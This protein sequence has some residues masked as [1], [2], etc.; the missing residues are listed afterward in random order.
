MDVLLDA[1]TRAPGTSVDEGQCSAGLRSVVSNTEGFG[2][3]SGEQ[4]A[5]EAGTQLSR[6][7]VRRLSGTAP[8]LYECRI[9][10]RTYERA[11]RLSRHM[12]THENARRHPCQRCPKSFNRADL[13]SRHQ[14]THTRSDLTSSP[15]H[16]SIQRTNRAGQACVGCAAAKARCEDQKPCRR[17]QTKGMVCEVPGHPS[18]S[19]RR[20]MSEIKE[21]QSRTPDVWMPDYDDTGLL[22]LSASKKLEQQQHQQKQKQQPQH[23]QQHHLADDI[24]LCRLTPDTSC[25]S[26]DH[27]NDL[28]LRDTATDYGQADSASVGPMPSP[29][30]IYDMHD[31]HLDDTQLIFDNIMNEILFMPNAADF[32]NQN[33][34][35][36]FHN[37][38]FQD[39]QLDTFPAPSIQNN[40]S[41]FAAVKVIDLTHRHARDIRAGYA[42]FTRSPWLWTP[43]HRDRILRDDENLT[44]NESSI[45]SALTPRS[46]GLAPNV[47]SCG[48]PTITAAMRD[49][50]YHLVSTMNRYSSRIPGFPSLDVINHV[51][52][53]FFV[54]QTYQV[55]NWIH[56][57]SMTSSDFI[58]ELGL[59][60]VVA[61]ST[62]ILLPAIGKMGLVLQDV[63]R[64]KLGELVRIVAAISCTKSTKQ[65]SLIEKT[66]L[67]AN[68]NRCKR[69]FLR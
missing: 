67:H 24:Q 26:N 64:V 7:R 46:S 49:K 56:V 41:E 66:M 22:S 69:G 20:Q 29:L 45:T 39:A 65:C 51:V 34:D 58:P 40:N 23:P 55:D 60:L 28:A 48:F 21:P 15:G 16:G 12:K 3:A 27:T 42:A 10:H 61:G 62:V 63:V 18:W 44:L 43:A 33:L 37:Y 8:T 4:Q 19:G 13:L 25:H 68:C 36:N 9:C 38:N 32:N 5:M 57:P 53:A 31:M 52:E 59:A 6:K 14:I 17:C 30:A 11:D 35:I 2:L 1:I 47:P 50:M 54:G